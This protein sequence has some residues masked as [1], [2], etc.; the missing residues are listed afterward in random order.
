MKQQ[1]TFPTWNFT[2]IWDIEEDE[3][4]PFHRE[5]APDIALSPADRHHRNGAPPAT[6]SRSRPMSPGR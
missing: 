4:Y 1:A 3:S 5:T 6:S 2:T